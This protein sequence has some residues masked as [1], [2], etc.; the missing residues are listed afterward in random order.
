MKIALAQLD[1]VVG[2]LK[3]NRERILSALEEAIQQGARVCVTP[4]LSLLGYP[5][6]DLLDRPDI[7]ARSDLELQSLVDSTRGKKCALIVGHLSPGSHAQK[8][9]NSLSVI[10]DGKIVYTQS[11]ILL[12]TYD[13]FDESRYFESGSQP[14]LWDCDGSK[15]AFLICED[16][17]GEDTRS[18]GHRYSRDPV[19]EVTKLKPDF[20]IA[21][22]ASPFEK[23]KVSIR[24]EL[25]QHAARKISSP[26][27]YVNQTGANDEVLFDG[28]SFVINAL[29]EKCV[30]LPAFE[31]KTVTVDTHQL[32]PIRQK[33]PSEMEVLALGLV[34]GIRSYFNRTGFKKAL[35]G[36]SGGIDSAIVASLA[37]RALGKESVL[38]V[39]M[40]SQY[41]SDHSLQDADTLAKNLGITL[42]NQEIQSVFTKVQSQIGKS[43]DGL[44]QLSQ[45]NLQSRIRGL[46]LMSISNHENRLVITTGN[47]SEIAM[48]YC[49]MYGD[50]VGAIAP[51]GDLYKTEVYALSRWV[52]E[53]WGSPIPER[54]ITKAPSAELRPNQT[55][56]DTLP[57]YEKLDP[58]LKSYL[59]DGVS[60]DQLA[61]SH[62]EWVRGVIRTVEISE[63]KRRQSAPALK[64][65]A[66]AFGIG[67]RIPVAKIWDQK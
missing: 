17:W 49:T 34:S 2:D 3:G 35:I 43:R 27:F 16:L 40:P 1:L 53:N 60:L 33:P 8:L 11:K 67:R 51:I 9:M 38:G 31:S 6:L 24:E 7:L 37:V 5:A 32:M 12:P 29:G 66:K 50:M 44:S 15:V 47:K 62:G 54:S 41:S 45:E 13:V 19:A 25:H 59:E 61:L 18:G 55:D 26:L 64:T 36:L 22:A 57:P 56:Q 4:E 10:D 42:E 20:L 58:V 48:G 30:S 28:R 39:T 52:N 46:F 65:S 23:E 21:I 63:Y 14:K